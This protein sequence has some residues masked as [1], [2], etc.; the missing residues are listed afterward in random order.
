LIEQLE[1]RRL[2]AE[3]GAPGEPPLFGDFSKNRGRLSWPVT[4][5]VARGFGSEKNP[6]FGTSTFNSGIDIGAS[7]GTPIKA[8]ARARVDYV[9]W[10]EGFGKCAILNHGG[11]FYTLYA[12]ASEISVPV[13]KDVAAGEVIG[14]VGDTGSTIGTAL[15]FEIRRGKQAL[16]PLEWLR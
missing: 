1:K 16:N 6:R 12:H 11:G 13:G 8:V 15:H 7:F 10:L 5:K 4:G 2:A 9:N 3:R 14:R